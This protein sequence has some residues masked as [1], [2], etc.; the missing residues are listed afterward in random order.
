M[1]M[2]GRVHKGL[3]EGAGEVLILDL[4]ANY[5]GVSL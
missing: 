1:G 4:H 5:T 2:T 3:S